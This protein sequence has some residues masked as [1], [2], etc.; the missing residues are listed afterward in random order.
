MIRAPTQFKLSTNPMSH[1]V[2]VALSGVAC[3]LAVTWLNF[4]DGPRLDP[5]VAQAAANIRI[6]RLA[7]PHRTE[8]RLKRTR[9]K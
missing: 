2:A 6:A 4:V 7:L 5:P 1:P 8:G 9:S 3:F